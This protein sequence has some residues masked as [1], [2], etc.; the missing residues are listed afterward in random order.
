MKDMVGKPRPNLLARCNPDLSR[1]AGFVVGGF[2]TTLDS[3]ASSLVTGGICRQTDHR[4]LDDAF[5]SFPSGHSSF[6]SAGLVYLML[7]LCAHFSLSIPYSSPLENPSR[8]SS[9]KN[10]SPNQSAPPLWQLAA[11]L[12]PTIVAIFICCSRYADFHHAGFEIIAGAIIG[13]FFAFV[14]FR[15][16]HLPIRRSQG[17]LAWRERSTSHAFFSSPAQYDEQTSSGAGAE[18]GM[19]REDERGYELRDTAAAE[20]PFRADTYDSTRPIVSR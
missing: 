3:E 15:L 17:I 8:S 20:G 10:S 7:W 9:V 4:K 2:G 19:A 18:I 16:Y 5:A 6:A 14:S 12:T 13:T 11:A 1:I